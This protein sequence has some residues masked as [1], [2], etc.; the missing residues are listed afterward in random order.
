MH[1]KAFLS[2][3]IIL[4]FP[5]IL[6]GQCPDR[7]WLWNRLIF[8][9]DSSTASSPEKLKELL[10]HEAGLQNCAYKSDST[11]SLLLQR[12]G[13][14]YF[15]EADF[16]KA[17]QYMQRAIDIININAGKP[18]VNSKHNIR[19]YYSLGWIYDSLNNMAG[20]M[21]FMDSCIA[22]SMRHNS[23]NIYLTSALLAR[24]EYFFNLGDYHRCIDYATTSERYLNEYPWNGT[25]SEYNSGITRGLKSFFW[26]VNALLILK[27]YDTAEKLLDSKI[28]ECKKTGRKDYLTT[29][30]SQLAEV[31]LHKKNAKK[32]LLSYNLAF[33]Y[34]EATRF[35]VGCKAILNNIGYNI[36]FKDLNEVDK[37]LYYC[38]RAYNYFN[39]D[40][41]EKENEAFESM[42]ILGN[43]ANIYVRK[44]LYDSAFYYFRLAL[45]QI[46]AGA[47]ETSI[48]NDSAD[49]F[50][51]QKKV[52]YLAELLI[53]KGDAFIHQYHTTK[54]AKCL[55]QA[56]AIYKITDRLLDRIK[57]HQSELQS[58]LF[59][60]SS[61][62]RLY[63][64]AIAACYHQGNVTDAFY[65]FEKSR[66]VLLN[67]QLNQQRWMS[68]I[69]ILK[70]TQL[71][72]RV[73][74]LEKELSGVDSSADHH[75]TQ[76]TEIFTVKQE[77]DRLVQMIKN[78]N[79]LYYQNFLDTG[80]IAI[81]YAQ[82]N[83]LKS[84]QALVELF[85]GDSA[86]YALLLTEK[87]SYL[88]KI[89]K[90]DF[91]ANVATY[92]SYLSNPGLMN[93]RFADFIK[94]SSVLYKLI[95]KDLP[96]PIGRIIIS[97]DGQYFPF[98]G[99]V[100]NNASQPVIYFLNDHAVSYAYSAR[101]LMNDFKNETATN[102]NFMGIAPVQYPSSFS[103][104]ALPGSD[105]S[106]RK[107]SGYFTGAENRIAAAASRNDFLQQFS[108]YRIIQLYTHAADSSSNSEPVIYFA[109]SALYL[110]DLI[111]DTK[112]VTSL[113]VLSACETGT[114]KVYNGEGVFSFN[115]GFAALGIPAAITNLWSVDNTSTYLLTELFYKWLAKGLPSDVAL[116]KAKLE[117]LQIGSKE[118]SMPYYWA[119]PVLVGK[120]DTIELSKSYSWRWIVLLACIGGVIFFALRKW[121]ILKKM[122]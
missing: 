109:D 33:K 68:E 71:K 53:D 94:T 56:I 74:I 86:V 18:F 7:P 97:P 106:L 119:G 84:H 98:E 26:K 41:Y 91:E 60:R 122:V 54:K 45:L 29:I 99:L 67:D 81:E 47:D 118:K 116:Q 49:E 25:E 103:L 70:Q 22:L 11:H 10:R 121:N 96:L 108:Q 43:I 48:L 23:S 89:N 15:F 64:H 59:W 36:Y 21:K 69:D 61:S 104:T 62:R 46:K 14:T 79:P 12:I 78:D 34:A 113:I 77:M 58:K 30:Y 90:G 5:I 2:I 88:T 107:I 20:K 87:N 4:L 35:D 40:E 9:R 32:A 72:K 17:A 85:S 83:L 51:K 55:N 63:E 13:A 75:R 31:Y 114:G 42:N 57:T 6:F 110:S 65:F 92:I 38:K 105:H 93:K 39:R 24:V 112:P 27:E 73:L 117:F 52:H 111:S 102:K 101:F 37:A 115:R 19:N 50:A 80:F 76:K 95:F 28:D 120:T 3:C 66:A 44:Q 16:L 8:L 1:S 82:Q 100:T